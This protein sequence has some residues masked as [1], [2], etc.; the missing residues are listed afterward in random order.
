M[1]ELQLEIVSKMMLGVKKLV[2]GL[3]HFSKIFSSDNI[4]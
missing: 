4:M 3:S 2:R 1:E